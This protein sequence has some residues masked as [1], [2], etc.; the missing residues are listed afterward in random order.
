MME[1]GDN[2]LAM[3]RY[4][5]ILGCF[6]FLVSLGVASGAVCSWEDQNPQICPYGMSYNLWGKSC[7][8]NSDCD[9]GSY[10]LNNGCVSGQCGNQLCRSAPGSGDGSSGSGN[11]DGSQ[12]AQEPYVCPNDPEDPIMVG[13]WYYDNLRLTG[14]S[15]SDSYDDCVKYGPVSIHRPTNFYVDFKNLDDASRRVYAIFKV[16][17]AYSVQRTTSSSKSLSINEITRFSIT[18]TPADCLNNG[19]IVEFYDDHTKELLA[20]KEFKNRLKHNNVVACYSNVKISNV[21]EGGWYYDNLRLTG[22]SMSDSYDDC[23]KYG[24]VSIH[25]PTNFY[26]DFK[27]LDDASRRVYAIFKVGPAYSVQR[28]TSSSKSLSINEITRFSITGTPADCLN[29]GFIVEFYD[30]H[31]KELLARK[32]FGVDL[33]PEGSQPASE[34]DTSEDKPEVIEDVSEEN[35]PS[36][37]VDDKCFSFGY[38]RKGQYCSEDKSFVDQKESEE[39]CENNFE[40]ESNVCIDGFCIDSGFIQK[41][42]NWIRNLFGGGN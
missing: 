6:V 5:F 23:V 32:A 39:V 25:R 29:N 17:P 18:G 31:T 8:S 24:P 13:G 36:C 30:D 26:V 14:T 33:L 34:D 19:F 1:E 37:F 21:F 10:C 28:T 20:R 16:G 3:K 7:S 11:G 35:C 9:S 42:L 38:R 2:N 4:L 15:M 40:C 12:E 41:I 27:N 22:T